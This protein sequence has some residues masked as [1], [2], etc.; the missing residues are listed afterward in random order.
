MGIIRDILIFTFV[1]ILFQLFSV[2]SVLAQDE[3]KDVIQ[4]SGVVATQDT[5]SGI[6]GAHIY[7]PKGGRGT[8]TNYYGYFSFPVLEG[9]SIV[10]SVV[11]FQKRSIIIPDLD[12]DSYTMIIAM[13][14]DTTYLPELEILPFPTEEMFKEAVLAYRLPNQDDLNNMYSNLD[15]VTLAE[16]ARIMPMDGSMNHRYF[17]QQQAI[18]LHDAYGPRPNPLLNPFAWADFFKSLKKKK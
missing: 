11:G 16:M 6:L 13:A 14:E 17:T 18:Y 7:V 10:I 2:E 3:H 5:A 1:G 12:E 4:F 15:P 8:T 9:D